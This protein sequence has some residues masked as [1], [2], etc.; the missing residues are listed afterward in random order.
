MSDWKPIETFPFK[1]KAV[2]LHYLLCNVEQRWIRFGKWYPSQGEWYYS[3]TN[4]RSQYAQVKGDKHPT[5]WSEIPN[6]PEASP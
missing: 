3:G 5:H 2:H 4:E 6:L 1:E